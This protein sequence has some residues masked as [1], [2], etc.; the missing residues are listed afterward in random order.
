MCH[1]FTSDLLFNLLLEEEEVKPKSNRQN[2]IKQAT[3]FI[4]DFIY[5]GRE[6]Y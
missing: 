6:I 1:I 5:G 4:N 3:K 2:E